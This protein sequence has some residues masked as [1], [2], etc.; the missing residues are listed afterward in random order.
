MTDS[1]LAADDTPPAPATGEGAYLGDMTVVA[2]LANAQDAQTLR[3]CL[4]AA[5]ILATLGD[6]Q[7]VQTNMLWANALGGVRVMVPQTLVARANEVIAEFHSGAY[8]LE[9]DA[10]PDLP[11]PTQATDLAL[12]SPD[13]AAFLSLFL[14]PVFGAALHW[15][16]SRRLGVRGLARQADAG[17][18]LSIAATALAFW[19]TRERD[20]RAASPFLVS[21]LMTFYTAAWWMALAHDQSRHVARSFGR[22]Y[23]HRAVWRTAAVVFVVMLAIGFA[24]ENLRPD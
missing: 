24:G 14:T 12:W 10:D 13:L 23:R 3:G 20:W 11:P 17:L 5:G 8:E 16:N 18:A 22:Q 6:A 2:R 4:V 19:L 7:T 9:G 15:L 1:S 21:G